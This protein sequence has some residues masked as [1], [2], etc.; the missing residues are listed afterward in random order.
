[1]NVTIKHNRLDI[2]AV[3]TWPTYGSFPEVEVEAAIDGDYEAGQ[4]AF[5]SL[6]DDERRGILNRI[7][8]CAYMNAETL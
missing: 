4:R 7:V 6:P 3:L 1:M 5:D 2:S 8:D